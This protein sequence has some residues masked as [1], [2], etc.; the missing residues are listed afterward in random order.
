MRMR[1]VVADQFNLSFRW[2]LKLNFNIHC[3][4]LKMLVDINF[5]LQQMRQ[6]PGMFKNF[7]FIYV[8]LRFFVVAN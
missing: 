5:Q 7:N 2:K 1:S 8:I 3:R 4:I 6:T